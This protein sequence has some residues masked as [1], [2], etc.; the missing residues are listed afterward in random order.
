MK[1]LIYKQIF[2]SVQGSGF[3]AGTLQ[4]FIR[5]AGCDMRCPIR[6]VCDEP[7][8]LNH[9]GEELNAEDYE[10]LISKPG[11]EWIHWTGGEPAQFQTGIECLR[12]KCTRKNIKHHI[13][14]SG[15]IAIENEFDWLTVSP[16]SLELIQ[17]TGDELI[18]VCGPW[19]RFEYLKRFISETEFK[20]YYL[21][22]LEVAGRYN[23]EKTF[24][25]AQRSGWKMTGQLHKQW[26]AR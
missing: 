26:G 24:E 23:F 5:L 11:S 25:F 9:S 15:L 1:K 16:K 13:Q 17:N 3:H 7:D 19:V 20:F 4:T 14:T 21:Q 22:P 12:N 6:K 8:S 2:E 18:L 10:N